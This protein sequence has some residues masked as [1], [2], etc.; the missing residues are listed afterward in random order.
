VD[1][2]Q[3][4]AEAREILVR[5]ADLIRPR[6]RWTRHVL[7]RDRRGQPV[8]PTDPRARRWC[9]AGAVLKAGVDMPA[10]VRYRASIAL[11]SVAD[12]DIPSINDTRSKRNVL[13]LFDR[14]IAALDKQI[15]RRARR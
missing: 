14:A 10:H 2:V 15:A 12:Q 9:M 4:L 8:A 11:N 1:D 13:T 6:G 5:A 7:A 3:V